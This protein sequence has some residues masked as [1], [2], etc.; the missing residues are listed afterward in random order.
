M[1]KAILFDY[2]DTLGNRELT[3]Y[4][5]YSLLIEE[6]ANTSDEYLKEAMKQDCMIWDQRGN[7]DKNYVKDRLNEVYN[8]NLDIED[9]WVWWRKN[10]GQFATNYPE[11]RE[12]L[13]KL[14]EKY[15]LACLTNGSN[16]SQYQKLETSNILDCFDYII[17]SEQAQSFKPDKA[18]FEYALKALNITNEEAIYIGDTFS[19]DIIGAHNAGIQ[20]IWL[21]PE[22]RPC[23]LNIKRISHI[24]E[25]LEEL[26]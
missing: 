2:D 1:I 13:L 21:A 22:N 26:C 18:M 25:L 23:K 19:A 24:K 6:Y 10:V 7:C 12:T 16:Q 5:T 15:L 4:N 11:V 14:K 9:M 3:A 8:L 17:T 20:C